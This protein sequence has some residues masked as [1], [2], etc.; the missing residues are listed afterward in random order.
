MV[1]ESLQD[2]SASEALCDSGYYAQSLFFGHL[3]LEKLC[4]VLWIK[5]SIDYPYTHNL[6]KLIK[7]ASVVI[8][9]NQV[10][11]FSDMNFLEA[12]GRYPETLQNIEKTITLDVYNKYNEQLKTEMQ[13]LINRLQ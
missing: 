12:K 5:Q 9:D 4:K 2:F 10:P 13:W 11:F 3:V 6:I 7:E 8:S 1:A